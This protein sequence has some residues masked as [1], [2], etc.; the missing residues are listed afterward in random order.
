MPGGGVGGKL[1]LRFDWHIRI[2][3]F[4]FE[5]RMYRLDIYRGNPQDGYYFHEQNNDKRIKVNEGQDNF[6]GC[7]EK[8][9]FH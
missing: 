4:C 3:V 2:K 7:S 6:G 5:K 1:K 9:G 8:S